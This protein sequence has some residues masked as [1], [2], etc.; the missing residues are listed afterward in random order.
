MMCCDIFQTGLLKCPC[1]SLPGG[2]EIVS[3]H[4]SMCEKEEHEPLIFKITLTPEWNWKMSVLK[5]KSKPY[6]MSESKKH[7]E[8][9]VG[10]YCLWTVAQSNYSAC[11][12]FETA[13]H[14]V[15]PFLSGLSF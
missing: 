8:H 4:N 7:F 1:V 6:L 2:L 12:S 3:C 10:N 13:R 11:F 9:Y 5:D 14:S 15:Y